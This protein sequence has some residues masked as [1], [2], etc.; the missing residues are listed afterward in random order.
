[1]P[2]QELTLLSA[3]LPAV[4]MRE[5]RGGREREREREQCSAVHERSLTGHTHMHLSSLCDTQNALT[6]QATALHTCTLNTRVHRYMRHLEEAA[7]DLPQHCQI[8]TLNNGPAW[9][10]ADAY[11]LYDNN[12]F[13]QLFYKEWESPAG[14]GICPLD[15]IYQMCD[16]ISN[17]LSMADKNIVVRALPACLSS[18][19]GCQL[20]TSRRR[21][22][23]ATCRQHVYEGIC[24]QGSQVLHMQ[25]LRHKLRAQ[26]RNSASLPA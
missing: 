9:R 19:A 22:T 25:L 23:A 12:V 4:Y 17:W 18:N 8:L 16:T 14:L 21:P 15:I 10:H 26:P 1:M 20:A 3:W 6:L 2:Q 11:A 13:E 24:L 5:R 7:S